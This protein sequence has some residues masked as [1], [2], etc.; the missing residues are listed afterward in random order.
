MTCHICSRAPN[1]RLPFY[2]PT[3]ARNQLYQLRVE[4]A[5]VILEKEFLGQQIE[6]TISR[7]TLQEEATEPG[8]TPR[9][10]QDDASRRWALQVATTRQAESA[11]RTRALNDRIRSLKA[12][13]KDKQTEVSQRKAV[14]SRQRSDAESAKFQL[15]EREAATLAG[16]QNN[17]KRTDHLWHSLH[18]KTAEARIFLCREAANLYVL[19]Q[20]AVE[21]D[22]SPKDIYIIGGVPILDLREMNGKSPQP[23]PPK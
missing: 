4:N 18:S 23:I 12:E 7:G 19:R 9:R 22:G 1:S 21:K 15:T 20:K 11:A 2:C 8:T 14:L 13:I 16:I 3:C 5:R 10:L 6:D 17:T